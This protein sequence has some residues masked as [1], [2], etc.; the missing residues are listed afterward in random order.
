MPPAHPRIPCGEADFQRIRR[1]RWLYVD[2]TRFLRRP[3]D[4][5]YAFLI[6]PISV[7]D[8]N[9]DIERLL[10]WYKRQFDKSAVE[11]KLG[12]AVTPELLREED[13]DAA[14]VAT[15]STYLVPEIPGIGRATAHTCSDLYPDPAKAGKNVA[16]I[17]GG[18]SGCHVA[19]WLAQ[20]G[21]AVPLMEQAS[22]IATDAVGINRSMLLDMLADSRVSIVA[23]TMVQE[24]RDGDLIADL[25]E[26]QGLAALVVDFGILG[27]PT[28][29][30]DVRRE[31]VARA[32]GGDLDHLRRNKLREQAM[33]IMAAGLAVVVRRLCDLQ[34]CQVESGEPGVRAEQLGVE[35]VVLP[36]LQH[37]VLVAVPPVAVFRRPG[38]REAVLDGRPEPGQPIGVSRYLPVPIHLDDAAELTVGAGPERRPAA[39]EGELNAEAH[40]AV[41]AQ[42]VPVGGVPRTGN[43]AA[44]P[45]RTAWWRRLPSGFR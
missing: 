39:P 5:R 23:N 38:E 41:C 34:G 21:K 29:P 28:I 8:F 27:E 20:Q 14:T 16:V 37:A 1:N 44:D 13:A 3:E 30:A 45:I 10:D 18:H 4:E 19:L 6:R 35:G 25:V 26:Q 43:C 33:P 9:L 32:G 22:D 36:A 11:V 31:E 7:P 12:T 24:L 15:G 42:V 2:K 17:G 40:A